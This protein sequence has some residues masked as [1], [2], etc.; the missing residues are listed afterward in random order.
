MA[1]KTK[2]ERRIK[3]YKHNKPSFSKKL[4][5]MLELFFVRILRQQENLGV[6]KPNNCSYS[7]RLQ[8]QQ[9]VRVVSWQRGSKGCPD[10]IPNNCS[11][12]PEPGHWAAC[13]AGRKANN[14]SQFWRLQVWALGQVI[15]NNNSFCRPRQVRTRTKKTP[16]RKARGLSFQSVLNDSLHGHPSCTHPNNGGAKPF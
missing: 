14:Y 6:K 3:L 11:P 10:P 1:S 13:P 5:L 16:S 9:S 8:V 7:F 15:A 4:R 12:K 2:E